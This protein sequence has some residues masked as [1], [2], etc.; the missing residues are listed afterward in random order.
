MAETAAA[1]EGPLKQRR[2]GGGGANLL[3]LFRA[4]LGGGPKWRRRRRRRRK[5][6]SEATLSPSPPLLLFVIS[7]ILAASCRCCSGSVVV[8]SGSSARKPEMY[9]VLN[10]SEIQNCFQIPP[11]ARAAIGGATATASWRAGRWAE[12]GR[13]RRK[14]R[15]KGEITLR[16]RQVGPPHLPRCPWGLGRGGRR[17]KG[18]W[19]KE[20]GRGRSEN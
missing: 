5:G 18:E 4:A 12:G 10:R 3:L 15:R 17:R 6:K 13:P 2:T 19:M 11:A 16:I 9:F 1:A 14:R 7:F 20:G 8:G